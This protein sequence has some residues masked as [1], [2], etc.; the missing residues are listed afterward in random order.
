MLI[1]VGLVMALGGTDNIIAQ[2]KNMG[3]KP[4]AEISQDVELNANI[5]EDDTIIIDEDNNVGDEGEG[6]EEEEKKS[7]HQILP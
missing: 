3:G 4:R 2:I 6:G 7:L 5:P 1:I